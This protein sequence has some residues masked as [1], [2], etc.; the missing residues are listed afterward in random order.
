MTTKISSDN[1]QPSTLATIGGGPKVANIQV[2]DSSY[3]V[4]GAN[5]VSTLGGY[6]RIN[7]TGFKSN[8]NVVIGNTLATA[9]AFVSSIQLNIQIPA[10]SANNYIVYVTNTDDGRVAVKPN[11]IITA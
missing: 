2:T 11:G 10:L 6:A 9:V 5:T 7:G 1:I 4:T 8:V 3:T